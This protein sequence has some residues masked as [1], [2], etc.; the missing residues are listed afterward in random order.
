MNKLKEINLNFSK[1]TILIS[2]CLL[3]YLEK[4]STVE[5][6]KNFTGNFQNLILFIYDL[7]N[8][9]DGFGKE[10]EMNLLER[11][12]K[13][14]GLKQVPDCLSQTNRLIESN[15][16]N[17]KVV[18]MLI[19]YR[20]YINKQEIHRIEHLEFLDEL[21]EFNLLQ[22]HSC[23]GVGLKI[24]NSEFEEIKNKIDLFLN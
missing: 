22:N 20:N 1:P 3:V 14:P 21:E 2:E 8:P 19:Y 7:V 11:N 9:N 24:E 6:L 5:I 16:T 13:I 17:A 12:I 15:F 4:N 23:F 10:M 18:D